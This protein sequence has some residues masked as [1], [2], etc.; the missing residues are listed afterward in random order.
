MLI[1]LFF[2]LVFYYSY[3]NVRLVKEAVHPALD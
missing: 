1:M 2:V 3:L